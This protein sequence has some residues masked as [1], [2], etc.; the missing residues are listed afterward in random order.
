MSDKFSIEKRSEIMSHIKSKDSKP[1]IYIRKLVFSMGYR[2]RLH[3]KDLPG[4][5]DIVFPM[6]RKVIF[7][8]GCFWHGH[9]D[10]KKAT[11]PMS[12]KDF[13]NKK[14]FKNKERDR[15]NYKKLSS[16]NWKY[17]IIW[18]CEIKKKNEDTLKNKI[19][20][21]LENK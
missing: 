8:N 9:S 1:E 5:P 11:L 12:N 7:V 19:K 14:I 18:Q 6:Y 3:R 4:K 10:C 21:F 20:D 15:N 2:Y 13:W 17:L 16:L